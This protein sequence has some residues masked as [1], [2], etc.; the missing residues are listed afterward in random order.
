MQSNPWALDAS[1]LAAIV[2][3]TLATYANR[4]GG[5]FLFQAIRPSPAVHA[6]LSYVPG[7]LFVS[8]VVPALVAG[9]VQQ[10]VGA[11]ATA[12]AMAWSR[13]LSVAIV[14]GVAAAWMVYSY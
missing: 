7:T 6:L 9:G 13:N 8:Y 14:A 5:Y 11:V 3:M 12:A 4:A 10:W 2:A 1:V